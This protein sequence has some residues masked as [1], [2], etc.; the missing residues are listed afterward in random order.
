M[1][2]SNSKFYKFWVYF[3]IS[4]GKSKSDGLRGVAKGY[5]SREVAAT[6]TVIRNAA[7]LYQFCNEKLTVL[8]SDEHKK[9]LNRLFFYLPKE[10]IESYRSSFPSSGVYRPIPG[11]QKIHQIMNVTSKKNGVYKRNFSCLCKFCYSNDYENCIY[12]DDAKFVDNKDQVRPIWHTFK[13]KGVGSAKVKENKDKYSS[14]GED[15]ASESEEEI[16]YEETEASCIVKCHDVAVVC[17]G[18]GFPYYLVKLKQ[19]NL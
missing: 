6:N 16:N 4:H 9:M 8:G 19:L 14:S 18:D 10:N 15:S 3:E 7:E 1:C 11:T 17:T 5:A 13:E 12:L 2:T